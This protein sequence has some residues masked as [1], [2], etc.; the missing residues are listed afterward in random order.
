M[1]A[2]DVTGVTMSAQVSVTHRHEVK[3]RCIRVNPESRRIINRSVRADMDLCWTCASCDNECPVNRATHRLS[4][5]KIVRMASF[6][7]MDELMDLPDLW[8]C[9]SCRHCN[10]V[11][12]SLVKPA[13]LIG[14]LR[15][16]VVR[17]GRL[18][19]KVYEKYCNFSS[20]FQR[21]RWHTVSQCIDGGIETLSE[22]KWQEWLNNPVKGRTDAITVEKRLHRSY[23]L[24]Q[25]ADKGGTSFCYTCSECSNACPIRRERPLFDPQWIVRM[26]HLRQIEEVL[27]SPS[28]WLC[29]RCR[30][31]SEACGALVKVHD[32]IQQLQDLAVENGIINPNLR[33]RLEEAHKGIYTRYIQEI[34]AILSREP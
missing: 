20:C 10:H 19:G 21:V 7:L 13:D 34:D 22:E 2:L 8:Y 26:V 14:F 9:I 3:P 15:G 24:N 30:R 1:H 25:L 32:V 11:C 33:L 6:G 28:I 18:N 31:C 16:E 23:A 17:Q 4:P 29:I 12:P 27:E 5:R